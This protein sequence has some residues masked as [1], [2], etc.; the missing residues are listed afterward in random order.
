L[1]LVHDFI[2]GPRVLRRM[3][4]RSSPG[5]P[6]TSTRVRG[7]LLI[8]ARINLVLVLTILALAVSLTRP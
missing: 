2:L 1:S 7:L 3:E 4:A 8:L 6:Q 5:S